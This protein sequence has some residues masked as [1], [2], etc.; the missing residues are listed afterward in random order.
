MIN[1]ANAPCSWGV[2]ESMSG[3]RGG[4]TQVLDEMQETGYVGTELGD[5]GFMPTDPAKLRQELAAHG[6]K[7]TGSWVSV[8]L[9]D[10]DRYEQAEAEALRTARLLAEVGGPD[11]YINMGNEPYSDP[12]RAFNTGRIKPEHSMSETQWS[13]FTEGANRLAEAVKRETGLR[14]LLHHHTGTWIETPEEID[15]FMA[16]TDPDLVGLCLD[17]GHCK[18][19]GGD[20][21]DMLTRYADRIGVVHFKDHEPTIAELSREKEMGAVESLEKGIFC[22]LGLGDVDFAGVLTQLNALNYQGWI[23]VEQDVLPGMGSPKESAARN[24]AYLHSI[25]L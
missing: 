9:H 12:M 22:E 8:F 6:L 15:K 4:Y 17:T 10:A 21:I 18:F 25:G 5:W 19:G 24:R 2:I 3:E 16:L 13:V 20:P 1:V 14:T 23:V 7:L 11:C